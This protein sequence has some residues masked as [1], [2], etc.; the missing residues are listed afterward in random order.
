M[1]WNTVNPLLQDVLR[2]TMSSSIFVPFR[3]VG[4]TSLSLQIG[5]RKSIDI[6]LFT[7]A[8]YGSLDFDAIDQYFQ[9][10][11]PYTSTNKGLPVAM[12]KSWYVGESENDAVKVDVYYTDS[13]IRPYMK[14]KKSAWHL[15]KI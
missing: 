14:R 5:H 1:Y 6:D 8:E 12:G 10:H 9:D 4:G 2:N 13:F 7:D 15:L 3:L 11:Y